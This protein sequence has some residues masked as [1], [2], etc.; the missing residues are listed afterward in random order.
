MSITAAVY[1]AYGKSLIANSIWSISNIGF[2]WYNIIIGENEMIFLF[3][4]YEMTAL[5]GV[6][7]LGIKPYLEKRNENPT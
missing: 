6:Y 3:G 4:I 1:V 2:I 5:Y 7:N